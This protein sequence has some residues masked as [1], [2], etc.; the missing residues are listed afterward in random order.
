M[1]RESTAGRGQRWIR[2]AG[3]V[4]VAVAGLVLAGCGSGGSGGSSGS[5]GSGPPKAGQKFN[6][7]TLTVFDSAPPGSQ[8]A[9]WN[10]Y[11]SYLKQV[12]HQQTGA[13]LTIQKYTSGSDL[14]SKVESSAVSG[15]GPDMFG[16]G[17]SFIGVIGAT[18]DFHTLSNADWNYLGGRSSFVPVQ[19]EDSGYTPSQDIGVPYES[20]PFVIAYNKSLFAKSGITSPPTTW[21]QYI[22][23]AQKV[24]KA[25]PGVS[26]AGFDPGDPTDPWKMVWSYAHQ[27]GGSFIAANGKSAS[28]DSPQVKQALQFYFAQLYQYHIVPP[29]S[30]TWDSSQMFSA[31]S[32]GKIAMMPIASYGTQVTAQGT[33]IQGKIGFAPLPNVPYGMSSRPPGGVP[34]ETIVSGN[35]WAI[36]NY[37]GSKT[38]LALE[39]AKLSTSTAAQVKQFQ[40][41]GWMP[42]TNAGVKAVEAAG[43]SAVTP[44]IAAEN[45]ETTTEITPAWSYAEDGMLAVITHIATKLTTSHSYPA[46]YAN[47]QLA[48]EQS[49]VTSHL[50]R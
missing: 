49:D 25:N 31:F 7:Q 40:L 9:P 14:S 21:T 35:Y 29:Q 37:A 27:L 32:Q 41:L 24:Q 13:T 16:Y 6:G 50:S 19:L 34:A 10:Q 45:G 4:V 20:I 1:D 42:V 17:S 48:T 8:A 28:M 36:P 22:A 47:S 3:V 18:H 11:Y 5:G 15:S 12:F 26:G 33:P 39:L 2:K 38:P 46:S 30:L 44:F 43:G 23:D